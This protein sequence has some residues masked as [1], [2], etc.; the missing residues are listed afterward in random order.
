MNKKK[1]SQ[2]LKFKK[3]KKFKIPKF[4]K[5]MMIYKRIDNP[6]KL[7]QLSKL[8]KKN[9]H[10]KKSN[11]RRQQNKEKTVEIAKKIQKIR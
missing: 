5:N 3:N 7:L 9:F 4:K 1:I 8:K 11:L 6:L 2:F 10:V